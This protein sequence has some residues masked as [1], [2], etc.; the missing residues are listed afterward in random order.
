ME[1]GRAWCQAL[2]RPQP[3]RESGPEFGPFSW[4]PGRQTGGKHTHRGHERG[5]AAGQA[6]EQAA[7]EQHPQV[8]SRGD[9]GEAGHEGQGTED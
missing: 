1:Q 8:L 4:V 6:G 2:K 3:G 7:S 5:N 9:D